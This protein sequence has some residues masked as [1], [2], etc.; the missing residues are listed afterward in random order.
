M[1]SYHLVMSAVLAVNGLIGVV[2]PSAFGER[3][4]DDKYVQDKGFFRL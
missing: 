2:V 3:S 4:W 1:K